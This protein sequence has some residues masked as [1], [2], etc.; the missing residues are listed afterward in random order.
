MPIQR[1]SSRV[2]ATT[3][4]ISIA[5]V[6]V[7]IVLGWLILQAAT[8]DGEGAIDLGD[9]TF[10]AGDAR[11]RAEAIAK[12]GPLLFSD[13]SGRGQRRPIFLA[14]LGD[15]PKTGWYAFDAKA[16]GADPDCFLEWDASEE[17]F[18]SV[19]GCDERTFPQDG[20]GLRRYL[21]SVSRDGELE[22]DLRERLPEDA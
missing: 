6:V 8:D 18:S 15:D 13:V 10:E 11:G 20:S 9:D 1:R 5:A 7:V 2:Q 17:E 3:L 21:V 4:A 19:G 12:D 14:H 22:V 16:P